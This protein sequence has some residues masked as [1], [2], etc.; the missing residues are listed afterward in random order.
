MT[1]LCVCV[2]VW[3]LDCGPCV[4]VCVCL[5]KNVWWSYHCK[6]Y[7]GFLAEK[8]NLSVFG[9]RP[10]IVKKNYA[11]KKILFNCL[12]HRDKNRTREW[13]LKK[14]FTCIGRRHLID[15]VQKEKG[16]VC[17]RCE[18]NGWTIETVL[19]DHGRAPFV[20]KVTEPAY[21]QGKVEFSPFEFGFSFNW[22][23]RRTL[24]PCGAR[25]SL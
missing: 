11:F 22:R 15:V 24:I 25:L 23:A 4:C 16:S 3:I 9:F 1:E 21:S 5:W 20:W 12:G 14:T 10:A 18:P 19:L 6:E 8:K 13:L 2:G 7:A 17:L